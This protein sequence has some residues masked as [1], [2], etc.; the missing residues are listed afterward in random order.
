MSTISSGVGL[1]S[2]L[3]VSTLVDAMLATQKQPITLL[4]GRLSDLS[5]KRTAF[6]KISANLLAI[7]NSASKFKTASYFQAAQATSSNDKSVL[8]TASAGASLGQFQIT[9]RALA[10]ANQ[11]I[12]AGFTTADSTPIGAG[13]FT[14]ESSQAFVNR[15]TRLSELRGGEGIEH[16]KF[17]IT[18]RAGGTATIDLAS[19]VTLD[20]VVNVINNQSSATVKARVEGD[21]LVLSDQTG[22]A[23]GTLSVVDVGAGHAAAQLG[24]ASTS[25]TGT[26]TGTNLVAISASTRLQTLNDGNGIR[27]LAGADDFTVWRDRKGTGL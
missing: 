27:C 7:L 22:L 4:Q 8:A 14:I 5:D 21:H 23:S 16:G 6:L 9:V 11:V 12:S 18:D 26:I 15:A 19:A 24:I 25:S 1:G 13:S 10:A 20:D 3:P 2:G 17:R